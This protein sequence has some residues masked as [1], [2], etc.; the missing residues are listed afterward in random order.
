MYYY[1]GV[2]QTGNESKLISCY[3]T[4]YNRLTYGFT[5]VTTVLGHALWS[6]ANEDEN[7]RARAQSSGRS[8]TLVL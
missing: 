5:Q 6:K 4:Q 3:R 7:V 1:I 2:D 8:S